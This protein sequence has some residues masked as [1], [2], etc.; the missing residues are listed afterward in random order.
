MKKDIWMD[1]ELWSR[2]GD[3]A[4]KLDKALKGITKPQPLNLENIDEEII[5][6][7]NKRQPHDLQT[8]IDI[9]KEIIK[10]R[11]KSAVEGLKDELEDFKDKNPSLDT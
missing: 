5:E 9:F 8:E 2:I 6:E 7:L 1:K 4:M 10:Q 11:L 3:T